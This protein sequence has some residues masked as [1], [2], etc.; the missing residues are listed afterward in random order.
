[1][2]WLLIVLN[3]N[4]AHVYRK[5]F[6][7]SAQESGTGRERLSSSSPPRLNSTPL[8]GESQ[9]W[10]PVL[11]AS[12]TCIGWRTPPHSFLPKAGEY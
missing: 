1:M 9:R 2:A 12:K 10:N 6:I 5:R 3:V 7:D 11:L 8:F 4:I